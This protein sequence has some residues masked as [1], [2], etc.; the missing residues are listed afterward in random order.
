M[1]NFLAFQYHVNP[2]VCLALPN[3]GDF[4]RAQVQLDPIDHLAMTACTKKKGE[5]SEIYTSCFSSTCS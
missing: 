5:V 2:K 3:Q 4:T 1:A